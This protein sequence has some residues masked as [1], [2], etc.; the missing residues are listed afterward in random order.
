MKRA[1]TKGP[2][3]YYVPGGGLGGGGCISM[4]HQNCIKT[5]SPKVITYE[6]CTPL[7]KPGAVCGRAPL[8]EKFRV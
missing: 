8:A 6:N 5:L 7:A 2:I 1:M 3:V 4:L